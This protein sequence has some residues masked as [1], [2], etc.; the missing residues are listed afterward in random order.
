MCGSPDGASSPSWS[1]GFD[2]WSP[3]QQSQGHRPRTTAQKLF[4]F[5]F[6]VPWKSPSYIRTF[7]QRTQCQHRG[8]DLS[9]SRATIVCQ[10][11]LHVK[12][13]TIARI[14]YVSGSNTA[15]SWPLVPINLVSECVVTVHVCLFLL[16]TLSTENEVSVSATEC[17][18]LIRQK[19]V[20]QNELW[21]Y[22]QYVFFTAHVLL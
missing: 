6:F 11:G 2:I 9:Q 21:P 5:F 4:V 1:P 22:Y 10:S 12:P 13:E 16:E 20:R 17:E 8:G 18:L 3:S 14:Y 7:E 19:Q 15:L